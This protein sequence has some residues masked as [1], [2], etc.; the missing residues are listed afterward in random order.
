MTD[1][2][3]KATVSSHS[4]SGRCLLLIVAASC[5]LVWTCGWQFWQMFYKLTSRDTMFVPIYINCSPANFTHRPS[6][7]LRLLQ[8]IFLCIFLKQGSTIK[9]NWLILISSF[10]YSGGQWFDP[11]VCIHLRFLLSFQWHARKQLVPLQTVTIKSSYW[12][13]GSQGLTCHS[14]MC[15]VIWRFLPSSASCSLTETCFRHLPNKY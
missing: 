9:T 5:C 13:P 14:E 1:Y 3:K 10:N 2:A 12:G 15:S 8:L 7:I 6:F 4:T 11:S